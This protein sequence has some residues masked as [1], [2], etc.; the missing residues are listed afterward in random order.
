[1]R[2]KYGANDRIAEAEVPHPDLGPLAARAGNR[3]QR[4]PHHA[5]GADRDLRQLQLAAHQR[6][7]RG[8][9]HADRRIGAPRAGDPADHQP[10]MGP[11]QEREPEPGRVHHRRADRPGRRSGAAGVRAHRRA[12]RRAGRDGNRLPARQDPGRVDA[13]RA[14]EARRHACPSSA[15]TPSAIRTA[16]QAPAEDRAGALDRRR[17]AVAADAPGRL[18]AAPRGRG[19]GRAGTRCSRRRST[20]RTC[21]RR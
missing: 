1:M 13:V 6:L 10:R 3:L 14:Q 19:A 4:H 16:S 12:R 5:A 17:E 21:S 7:R 8:D 11:G 2:D 20:T 9:H 18:P 15:S